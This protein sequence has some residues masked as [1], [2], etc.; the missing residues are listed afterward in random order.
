MESGWEGVVD[1]DDE[2][3]LG[4]LREVV[5]CMGMEVGWVGEVVS[6]W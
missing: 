1:W 2:V 4:S 3:R 5:V 6:S